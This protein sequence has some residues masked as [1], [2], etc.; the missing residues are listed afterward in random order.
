MFKW[1]AFIS[2]FS[3]RMREEH[4]RDNINAH[5]PGFAHLIGTS[6][7]HV[8]HYVHKRDFEGLVKSLL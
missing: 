4:A 8:H 2:G 3:K 6:E 1:D 7:E 5:V